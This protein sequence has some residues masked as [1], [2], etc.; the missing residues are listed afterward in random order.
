LPPTPVTPSSPTFDGGQPTMSFD[1]SD[2]GVHLLNVTAS[3]ASGNT[4]SCQTTL[5][6]YDPTYVCQPCLDFCPNPVAVSFE[7]G[8]QVLLP[9]FE[10]GDYS[11]FQPYGESFYNTANCPPA[12]Q[13]YSVEYHP[14]PA[15]QS[16]FE[17]HWW[18]KDANDQPVAHCLQAITYGSTQYVSVQ[19]NVFFETTGN[20]VR[21]AGEAGVN[22]FPISVT[23]LPSGTVQ[24]AVPNADGSYNLNFALH[25][26]DSVAVVQLVLPAGLYTICP[27]AFTVPFTGA[28]QNL[29]FD[30]GLLTEGNCPSI[31]ASLNSYTYRRC[32]SNLFSALYCNISLDTAYDAYLVVDLD[33]LITLQSAD[34]PY[35]VNADGDYVFQLGDVPPLQCNTLL[36]QAAISCDAVIGQT[37]CN[38]VTAYPG[39][40]CGGSWTGP[41]VVA[42]ARCNGDLVDLAIW[43]QGAE[44]MGAPLNFIVIED[45]IMYKDGPFQLTAGDSVTIQVPANGSTWRLEAEQVNGYPWAGTVS[46]AIEGCGGLNTPGLITAF[47]QNDDPGNY[48]E[49]CEQVTGSYDPNDKTAVPGGYS[50]EHTIRANEDLEYKIRFQNT[51][52]DAA[53]RVVVV[54]TL[55]SLLDWSTLEPGVASHPYRL[56]IYPGGILNFVFDPITLPDSNS[57][58]AGSHGFVCFRIAQQPDLPVGTVIEN[59]AAIY[60][61]NNDPII[62]NTAFQTI[63]KLEEVTIQSQTPFLPGVTATLSPNPFSEQ[64]V[65]DIRGYALKQGTLNLYDARGRLLRAQPMQGNQTL[66]ERQGLPAGILFFRVT[67][68]GSNVVTGKLMVE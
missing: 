40:L 14:G 2:L 7:T 12:T 49:Y 48:D 44:D 32:Q 1:C 39:D 10:A 63:G 4:A 53:Y 57:N 56:E 3:D 61:D 51:G 64:A 24:T 55:S 42:T 9:A 58:E 22:T 13:T 66:I 26:S 28:N 62:T 34:L 30:F 25:E 37:L 36:M 29:T 6:V 8:T 41:E 54:D 19:G 15:G 23:L 46:A 35:T 43:N 17:R 27:N 47:P 16:W 31:Q 67:E 68:A 11:V 65:L 52:N 18:W 50:A 59:T 20:C 60:F 21:D 38:S 33:S 5:L 45:F